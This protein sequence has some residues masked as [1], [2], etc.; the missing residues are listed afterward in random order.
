MSSANLRATRVE[1]YD[2]VVV[3]GGQAGLSLGQQLATRQLDFVILD[4][5]AQIGDQW[6]DR[7]DSLRLFTPAKYSG[8]PGMVFPSPPA[9]L[10]DKDEVADYLVRYADRF[11]L[12][13]R[14]NTRVRSLRRRGDWF[15]LVTD[16]IEYEAKQVVIATGPF[17]QPAVPALASALDP[18]IHQRHSSAYRNPFDLPEGGVL[19]VGAGPSGAQVALELSRFRKVWLAGPDTGR[20]PR[21]V[22]GRDVFDWLWP[23]F[24]GATLDTRRGRF[25]RERAR[26]G[27]D[28]LIGISDKEFQ[29]RGVTR[30]PR[31]DGQRG[32]WPI[33]GSTLVQPKVVLWCTG[34]RP[35]FSWI[36]L[37]AFD[38]DGHPRH[39]RGVA[40]AVP[41]LY[42]LGQRFQYRMTSSLI[43][44]TGHDAAYLAERIESFD[45]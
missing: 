34:F 13:V 6:R 16:G 7:W 24:Q 32:G 9:H 30:L 28:V 14:T 22:L 45:P 37:P 43:G 5:R 19:V 12:P 20:L 39:I 27:G 42:F 1:R 8:L 41:G 21:R 36:E 38:E 35:N 10:P 29:A 3:G 25:L 15:V 40:T 17:Q 31:L 33:C 18:S 44:G 26:S 23:I 4:D 11:A 2:V